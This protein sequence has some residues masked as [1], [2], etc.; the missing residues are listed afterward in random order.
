[1]AWSRKARKKPELVFVTYDICWS[2]FIYGEKAILNVNSAIG[3][4]TK[5]NILIPLRERAG[6]HRPGENIGEEKH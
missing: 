3:K 2:P 5:I 6:G 4:G 1:M